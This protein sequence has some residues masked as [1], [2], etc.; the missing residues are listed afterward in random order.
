MT[1]RRAFLFLSVAVSFAFAQP[2]PAPQT[3]R[4]AL[5]EMFFGKAPGAFEKHLPEA[6]KTAL[7]KADPGSGASMLQGFSMITAQLGAGGKQFQTYEAGSTLFTLEDPQ[8]RSKFEI[9]VE[10][11]DL[12]SE[13]DEIEVS[14]KG[15]KDGQP[16]IQGI[17]P[18]FTFLMKQEANIWRLSEITVAIRLPLADPDFLKSL[19]HGMKP[20]SPLVTQ[21]SAPSV[22][23]NDS[24]AVGAMRTIMTA[25]ATY[26]ATYPTLGYTCSL[27]DLDGFG[28][29]EPNE[30]QA[31][32][33]ESR[34]ASGKKYG[35]AYTL[36]G[37]RGTPSAKY[38][39]TAVPIAGPGTGRSFCANETGSIRYHDDGTAASCWAAGKALP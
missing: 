11:D 17:A 14:F 28:G 18:R 15:Y 29:G 2:Q 39:L 36:A 21:S 30:H 12:R 25:Q 22:T 8:T 27:S 34:L 38:Q 37:C 23:A 13:E 1:A 19:T 16:Q 35:Y 5:I 31:M 20:G 9:T 7:R 10:R 4:Q 6:T 33:I 32:L 3:A 26:A 24:A